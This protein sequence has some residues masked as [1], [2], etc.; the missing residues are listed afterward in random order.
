[1]PVPEQ[2]L[3]LATAN[4]MKTEAL[5]KASQMITLLEEQ[6]EDFKK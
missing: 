6:R 1:M 3:E 4:Q 5:E 2:L